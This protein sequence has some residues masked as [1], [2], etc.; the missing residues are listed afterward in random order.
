MY[1]WSITTKFM[2]II[3]T[4]ICITMAS[5][6]IAIEY[7]FYAEELNKV[8]LLTNN[9]INVNRQGI[10]SA[11]WAFDT[12]YIHDQ[13]NEWKKLDT[14]HS[15]ELTMADGTVISVTNT[16]TLYSEAHIFKAETSL[17]TEFRGRNYNL[18]TLKIS[19]QTD[20]VL[21]QVIL[22]LQTDAYIIFIIASSLLF[23]CVYTTKRLIKVPLSRLQQAIDKIQQGEF[24]PSLIEWNSRDE[25]GMVI[26]AFNTMQDR[27]QQ[28]FDELAK[29][30]RELELNVVERTAYL[31]DALE[32]NNTLLL[33]SPLPMGV[34]KS[35]GQ[36]ILANDAYARLV[37]TTREK[38]IS[39][40]FYQINSWK[41]SGLLEECKTALADHGIRSHEISVVSSFGKTVYVDIKI[42][43]VNL[44]NQGHLLFQFIDLTERKN[45]EANLIMAKES[46]ELATRSKSEFLANMSHEIRTPM[47]AV[48]GLAQI[49]SRTELSQYQY[50]CVDKILTSGRSLLNIINDILDISM[51]ESGAIKLEDKGFS[52]A[53]VINN[54]LAIIAPS[55]EE[56]GVALNISVSASV[57]DQLVGDSLRLQ[58]VLINLAGNAVKFTTI[59]SVSINITLVDIQDKSVMLRFE[60]IDTGIG[61]SEE[62]SARLFTPFTQVDASPTRQFGGS[63]LGLA[64]SRRFVNLMGGEIGVE[65]FQGIGSKFWFTARF[66]LND[67]A[68]VIDTESLRTNQ[69]NSLRTS[70]RTD[71][72]SGLSV[73]VVEDN[74]INQDVTRRILELEGAHVKMVNNGAEAIANLKDQS[75]QFDIILMD[76]QMPI[77]DG[78]EATK[79]I[80]NELGL[81]DIPIIALSAGVMFQQQNEANISGMNGFVPKPIDIDQLVSTVARYCGRQFMANS[82]A[83]SSTTQNNSIFDGVDALNRACGNRELARGLLTRFSA[84]NNSLAID[85]ATLIK[86]GNVS[87]I[88]FRIHTLRGVAGNVG[89][90]RLS[91]LAG[92]IEDILRRNSGNLEAVDFDALVSLANETIAVIE[93]S[94]LPD[95]CLTASTSQSGIEQAKLKALLQLLKEND[96]AAIDVFTTMKSSIMDSVSE[97]HYKLIERAINDLDFSDALKQ[98]LLLRSD[99]HL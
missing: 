60:V 91:Q 16:P 94:L 31:S 81:T 72:L 73:L 45:I 67:D 75:L 20:S 54:M 9:L 65:S 55:A 39:Q 56:K 83:P 6:F 29:S 82:P 14:L 34:Y 26:A 89:A 64:I 30:K 44:N 48:L 98:L 19:L 47:N 13:M 24:T 70:M 49:L 69:P 23:V 66:E 95:A 11:L 84:Q 1:I 93:E 37:G 59:G 41:T 86:S 76:V 43:P 38:L 85:L 36:C 21:R 27:L 32:F 74:S 77:M 46:A 99:D 17:V 3:V 51:V 15:A 22:H 5:I 42:L 7:R 52:L 33:S 12:K 61:I 50:E 88:V 2:I 90:R 53:I 63:G 57:P 4:M 80:R 35:D 78:Y 87:E 40:N 8:E 10:I 58:Q 18:G 68:F 92:D 97:G 62:G 79:R 71:C 96:I 28:S 25:L